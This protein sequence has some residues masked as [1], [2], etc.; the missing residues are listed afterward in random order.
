MIPKPA[1]APADPTN[2]RTSDEADDDFPTRLALSA[3]RR[4]SRRRHARAGEHAC[5]ARRGC[6][7]RPPDGRIRREAVRRRRDVPAARRHGR[8]HVRRKRAGGGHALCG[9]GRA[10]RRRVVRRA[11]CRRADADAR[12][13]GGALHDA[14][15]GSERRDQAVPRP[16]IRHRAA[17][18]RRCGGVLA[19]RRRAAAAVVVLVRCTAARARRGAR[20]AARHAVRARARRLARAGRRRARLHV[21]ACGPHA[22][23]RAAR[24]G[25]QGGRPAHPG[26][27]GERP[28][29]G[30]RTRALGRR[31]DL[32]RP[33]RPDR[34]DGARRHRVSPREPNSFR[35]SPACLTRKNDAPAVS[36]RGVLH[37]GDV[38]LGKIRYK[39]QQD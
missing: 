25:N 12:G 31:R 24:A 2:L 7:A 35:V 34:P 10:R 9:A 23:E 5:R 8:S 26:L 28:R 36:R 11:L 38:T 13:G 33:H 22:I 30:A 19:R 18:G 16:R 39:L 37:R 1:G 27:H 4:P 14:R 20:A 32:H 17:G 6:A 3:R 15:A 29:Q 21:V